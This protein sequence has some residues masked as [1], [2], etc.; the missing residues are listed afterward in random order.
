MLIDA[1]DESN[2]SDDGAQS[3]ETE[4][5][6]DPDPDPIL[7]RRTLTSHGLEHPI[8]AMDDLI[9]LSNESVVFLSPR[10]CRHFFSAIAPA[11]LNE[12]SQTPFPDSTLQSMVAVTDSLGAKATLWELMG[13]NRPTMQLMVRLCSSAPYLSSILTNNPGMIDELIDS[14]LMNRLPSTDRL[15]AQ[16]IE[17]CRGAADIDLILHGFKNSA[18]LTIGVRDILGKESVETTHLALSDTAEACLRRIID[19]EQEQLA[20]QFGDPVNA[21]GEPAELVALALG[22]F[23]GREPNYLSDLDVIFLYSDKGETRRR[24]GGRRSTTNNHHFFNQLSQ[25][26]VDRINNTGENGRLY[27]LDGRL[28]PT[29]DQGILAVTIED[30]LKRFRQGISPLWQRLAICKARAVSGSRLL[31]QKT[32]KAIVDVISQTSWHGQM[33]EEI[34]TMRRRMQE[35]AAPDNLKRGEGG[36]VDV[37][38]IAQMLTLRHASDSPQII[39]SGTLKSLESLAKAGF[40]GEEDALTLA[41]GYRLLRGV[42]ARL[43]LL[44]TPE[45]HELPNDQHTMQNLAFLLGETDPD[46]IVAQCQQARKSNRRLF[47]KIFDDAKS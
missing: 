31:K 14:L 13:V 18:H 16:S 30:F 3:I 26:V 1:P 38:V 44:S 43:R 29:G 4:L 7:V 20:L 40:L 12:I 35:T 9:A 11:L 22:K 37:E 45:R 10:R 19:H 28:R 2:G 46:M 5:V 6:L 8:R 27:E 41:N 36:T 34:R 25:R 33:A 15:D 39:H 23:G 21:D 42:E 47:D 17:L 32:N 24:V